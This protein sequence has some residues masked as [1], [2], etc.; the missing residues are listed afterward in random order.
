[1]AEIGNLEIKRHEWS[2]NRKVL[3][4]EKE[5]KEKKRLTKQILANKE[6]N[7]RDKITYKVKINCYIKRGNLTRLLFRTKCNW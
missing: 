2:R 1:M 5:W 3:L 7:I 4:C 6:L